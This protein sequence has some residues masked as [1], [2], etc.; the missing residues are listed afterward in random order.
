[1]TAPR[2]RLSFG[3]RTLVFWLTPYFAA[4]ALTS[5][6]AVDP[7]PEPTDNFFAFGVDRAMIE[8]GKQ[9]VF[10]IRICVAAVLTVIWVVI[11]LLL[12]PIWRKAR[13]RANR[14]PPATQVDRP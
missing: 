4:L 14:M 13:Q 11:P 3:L 2:R 6:I 12:C 7:G 10:N 9:I 1:M 5:T 8:V